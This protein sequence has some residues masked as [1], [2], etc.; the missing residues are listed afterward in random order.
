[1]AI[2]LIATVPLALAQAGGAYATIS[3]PNSNA[4]QVYG[5]NTAGDVVGGFTDSSNNA[6]G[7]LLSGG[8][9]TQLDAPGVVYGTQA[10][11]VNDMGQV[12]GGMPGTAGLWVYDVSTQTYTV[13]QYGGGNYV[14]IT[15]ASINNTG[16]IVGWAQTLSSGRFVGLEL[17]GSTFTTIHLPDAYSTRLTSINNTGAIVG[18][19]TSQTGTQT[20]YWSRD[21]K[22]FEQFVIAG[23]PKAV[24]TAVNDNSVFTGDYNGKG[25][26]VAFEWQRGSFISIREPGEPNTFAAGINNAGQIVGY[27]YFD[28]GVQAEGLLWTP[29]SDVMKQ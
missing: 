28:S 26:N 14:N 12:V 17:N 25:G 1:L 5:I 22:H 10:Y 27:Y 6:H 13:Y 29:P 9:Y 7:F 15:G 16:Q 11:G 4:T 21:G 2:F 23:V 19:A 18:V 24:I 8:V 20:G 3:F